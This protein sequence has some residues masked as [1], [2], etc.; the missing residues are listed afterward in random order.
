MGKVS[1]NLILSKKKE[2]S[3]SRKLKLIFPLTAGIFLFVFIVVFIITL[4]YINANIYK[5]NLLKKEAERLESKI[6]AQKASEGIYTV[7]LNRL[8]ALDTLLTGSMGFIDILPEITA[9]N[10]TGISISTANADEKGNLSVS[11][12]A[13]SS[14]TLDD[15]VTFL[16]KKEEKKLYSEIVASSIIREKKGAYHLGLTFKVNKSL[17]K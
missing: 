14:S 8:S 3:L 1:V 15:L 4:T 12:L 7:S 10:G 9:I 5:F 2:T 16:N 11:L 13:S 17:I 6:S